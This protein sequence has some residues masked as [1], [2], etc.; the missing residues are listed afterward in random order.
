MFTAEVQRAQRKLKNKVVRSPESEFRING[1]YY[2]RYEFKKSD[3]S[4]QL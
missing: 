3:F 1:I 4:Y 2:L